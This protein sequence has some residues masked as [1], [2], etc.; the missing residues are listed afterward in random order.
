MPR[1]S[2]ARPDETAPSQSTVLGRSQIF[3]PEVINDIHMKAEL[4]R[5][6]MRGFSIFQKIPH[7]D[8]LMTIN[9]KSCFLLTKALVPAMR[10][11]QWG[12]IVNLSSVAGTL[13][14]P[15]DCGWLGGICRH[16]LA[17]PEAEAVG[18]P[19]RQIHARRDRVLQA[20]GDQ[21]FAEAERHQALD[22][23]TRHFQLLGDLI[24]GLSRDV[25]EPA[26]TGGVVKPGSVVA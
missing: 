17:G 20:K 12:R 24:L 13:G 6:R 10:E 15:G 1:I 2:T 23:R 16:D 11:R 21:P 14:N 22:R 3:T 25:V 18:Q 19:C 8:D 9:V 5:Y 26:G 4:G 7:W